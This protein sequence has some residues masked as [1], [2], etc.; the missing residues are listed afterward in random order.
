MA[1]L[2]SFSCML[3]LNATRFIF[4][5]SSH[6]AFRKFHVTFDN[7]NLL[8]FDSKHLTLLRSMNHFKSETKR[9]STL[10]LWRKRI[11]TNPLTRQKRKFF[12]YSSEDYLHKSLWFIMFGV[13]FRIYHFQRWTQIVLLRRLHH[14]KGTRF[15][16]WEFGDGT[17]RTIS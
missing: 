16:R 2:T 6:D 3:F 8:T 7:R 4:N 15:A 17:Y 1:R 10:L 5:S 13:S 11:T 14:W 9:F 12:Y